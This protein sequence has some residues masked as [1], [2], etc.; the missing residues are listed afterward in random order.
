MSSPLIGGA[1]AG[2]GAG[3]G[4]TA[5]GALGNATALAG[6]YDAV[7]AQAVTDRIGKFFFYP[8][9]ERDRHVSG[10]VFVHIGVRRS[11]RLA[12]LK[13]NRSSRVRALDEAA[14][15]MVRRAAPLPRI[16]D[17][18]HLDRVDVELPVVFSDVDEKLNPS[19]GNCAP[20]KNVIFHRDT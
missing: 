20:D 7:W 10:A 11:G 5:N 17:R 18:M 4:G 14:L 8:R 16:P 6:C 12:F 2:T 9:S 13:V 1:P 15:E 19:P 3:Q